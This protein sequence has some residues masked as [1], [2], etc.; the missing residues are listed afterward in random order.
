MWAYAALLIALVAVV[1]A[2]IAVLMY[3]SPIL[4]PSIF[5]T[6]RSRTPTSQRSK[7]FYNHLYKAITMPAPT[8]DPIKDPYNTTGKFMTFPGQDFNGHDIFGMIGYS[9]ESC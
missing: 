4:T 8:T 7:P 5:V 3:V 2:L 6:R 9:L 1:A